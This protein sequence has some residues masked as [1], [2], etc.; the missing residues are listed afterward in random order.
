MN[1]IADF[2]ETQNIIKPQNNFRTIPIILAF[3]FMLSSLGYGPMSALAQ[4]PPQNYF[5]TRQNANHTSFG[6]HPCSGQ[7]QN[8]TG[9]RESQ[10][11]Q[12]RNQTGNFIHHT[13]HYG[14]MTRLH[15]SPYANQTNFKFNPCFNQNTNQTSFGKN[16]PQVSSAVT[17]VI[18]A[19][20]TKIP[21]WVKNNAKW[22]S[23][24]QMGDSDFISGIQ[25]LI[26]QGIMKIPASQA[27]ST[28]S[29]QIP[30]WIKSNASW[31]ASG[32][33]S[34]DD[35]IKGIQ[36]LVSNEIIKI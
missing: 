15:M 10:F 35:F 24:N 32:Q 1:F 16:I 12:Y 19:S 27:A 14:N 21:S 8:M 17:P 20:S 3:I 36:W 23:Q 33:I 26:Q 31:W 30:S 7:F 2:F 28:E 13:S 18:S 11:G 4:D 22:W 9:I 25:Y 6:M 29:N 5:Q 34:D